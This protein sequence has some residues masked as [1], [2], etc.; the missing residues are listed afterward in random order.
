MARN[1]DDV[2][3]ALA[4]EK[5]EGRRR[6]LRRT[7]AVFGAGAAAAVAVDPTAAHATSSTWCPKGFKLCRGQCRDLAIN[8]DHCGA[9]GHVCPPGTTC[10]GGACVDC[11]CGS[12]VCGVG[13]TPC[14]GSC[15][16]LQ[17][18]PDHCGSCGNACD[19][20]ESCVA[21]T[22][23]TVSQECLTAADCGVS[24]ECQT[25]TCLNNTCG[26]TYALAGTPSGSQ[27]AGDCQTRV[28]DGLGGIHSVADNTDVP[29]DDGNDCTADICVGGVPSHP[30][31]PDGT[32]CSSGGGLVCS[33]GVCT[34]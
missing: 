19:T 20:G 13:E 17:T 31:L 11:T 28:C 27:T 30:P 26:V 8:P 21:G 4:A 29:A 16:N 1:L 33:S 5:P 6:F 9:C 22:C 25:F 23:Q 10:R 15:V 3:R 7:L 32:L 2:S 34:P 14:G 12:V 24:D 18:D